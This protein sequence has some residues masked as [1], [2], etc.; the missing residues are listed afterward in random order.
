MSRKSFQWSSTQLYGAYNQTRTEI[1]SRMFHTL[2]G[3]LEPEE[4]SSQSCGA[5]SAVDSH[6]CFRSSKLIALEESLKFYFLIIML[7]FN[8]SH[9]QIFTQPPRSFPEIRKE[10]R[11]SAS[12]RHQALLPALLFT[13]PLWSPNVL[14]PP[15]PTP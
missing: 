14:Q 11:C 4:L 6:H 13:D 8:Y 10:A 9:L 2:V 3:C 5:L 1:P 15:S 12:V 7:T